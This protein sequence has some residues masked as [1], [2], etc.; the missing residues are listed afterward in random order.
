MPDPRP[1]P[2]RSSPLAGTA[3][4]AQGGFGDVRAWIPPVHFAALVLAIGTNSAVSFQL[5]IIARK[6]FGAGDW[7]TMLITAAPAVL[8]ILSIFWGDLLKRVSIPRYL[9]CYWACAL[10]PLG[11]IALAGEFWVFALAFIV[12]SC[13][14]A[15]WPTVNGEVL[16]A[17]YPDR[18]R[19]R[20]YGAIVTC[21]TLASAGGSFA[22]GQWLA[23]DAEAFRLF[24]PLAI[25]CQ[26]LGLGLLTLLLARTGVLGRR[27]HDATPDRRS[28]GARII[29]PLSHTA[30]VLRSDR[31]FARYEAAFMTYGAAWMICEALKPSLMVDRLALTYDQIGTSAFMTFQLCVAAMTFPAG[32]LMDKLGPARLCALAFGLYVL[33]P[34]ALMSAGDAG[35]LMLASA[36][37]GACSAM[38]NAGW[39]LGPVSLAP[40]P[41]KVPQYVAI[42]ASMVGLRGTVFQFLGVALYKL[43]GSFTASFSVAALAFAWG[44]WQMWSLHRMMGAE[45][46][47]RRRDGATKG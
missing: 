39:M 41:E 11:V 28:V 18:V 46:T 31:V 3:A 9:A 29:E 2:D 27:T 6:A 12:A 36:V 37:Y 24:I 5:P 4:H 30:E 42:H 34:V 1:N 10:L 25:A 32:L 26:A 22:L 7:G 20:V 44:S 45:A 16:K 35:G 40:S 14:G 17:I 47:K 33:Y 19:G 13:G 38:V 43:T 15:A 8:L 23:R 21:T